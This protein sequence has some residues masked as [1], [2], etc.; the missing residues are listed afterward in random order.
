VQHRFSVIVA[1]VLGL[2]VLA[3]LSMVRSAE[4][5][6][7]RESRS[8]RSSKAKKTERVK[9]CT[10]KKGKR[11]CKRVLAFQGHGVGRSSLRA[12]PLDRPSGDVWLYSSNVRDEAKVNI[13]APEGGFDEAALARLDELFRCRRSNEARAVDPRLYEMLSRV[14]DHFGQRRIELVSG[15][16]FLERDSSRHHHAS[17]MDIRI[18]GVTINEMY[19]FAET[20]D[21]GG[22]GVGIYPNS[23]FVHIDFRAPGEPSYRWTDRSGPDRPSKSS[24]SKRPGR[25]IRAKKPTS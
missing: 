13:Y 20:L 1:I 18:P 23:G 8:S 14:Y 15:F 11:T 16:R 24:R 3:P 6:S 4:A 22:M 10:T 7:Q 2:M 17:A 21:Q 5:R 25:T 9:V 19:A 12:E